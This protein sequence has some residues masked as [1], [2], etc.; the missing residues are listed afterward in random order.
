MAPPPVFLERKTYRQ[1]RLRDSLRM[2]PVAGALLMLMPLT[3]DRDGA[4]A[5]YN[6]TALLYLFGVWAV[7]IVVIFFLSRALR[8]EDR[9]GADDGAG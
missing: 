4:T 3:W 2:L 1:R 9:Q 6:S 8:R 5:T 7:L